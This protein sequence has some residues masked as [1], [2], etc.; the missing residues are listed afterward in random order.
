M[1]TINDL[2][3]RQLLHGQ[4]AMTL[5]SLA[6][7]TP[8]NIQ[9]LLE[10]KTLATKGEWEV[11]WG[12]CVKESNLM[13]VA[14]N[15]TNNTYMVTIRGTIASAWS[16]FEDVDSYTIGPLPW[17]NN[18]EKFIS[19]GMRDGWDHLNSMIDSSSGLNLFQFVQKI[20]DHSYIYVTGH[21]QGGG[22]STVM[23]FYLHDSFHPKQYIIPYTMAGETAGN[24][25]FAHAYNIRFDKQ[26]ET[27]GLRFFNNIDVV[28][29]GFSDMT[30]IKSLYGT[31]PPFVSCPD[32]FDLVIDTLNKTLP[33]YEQ[34]KTG[35][36]LPGPHVPIGGTVHWY[37]RRSLFISELEIQHNH[38][39]YLW[40]L[41]APLTAGAPTVWPPKSIKAPRIFSCF[42]N[43]LF[44]K[45]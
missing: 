22:L 40:L 2:T 5:S 24:P 6:Y 30:S 43:Y 11:V 27:S 32:S 23:A 14:K 26:D 18:D 3:P 10:N 41:G 33:T 8:Y 39:T 29:K 34:P 31:E 36:S 28:P 38:L 19:S 42:L 16:I 45:K 44:G 15:K 25:A 35:V 13:F 21:S 20:P 1:K 9:N 12:P 4:I 37:N 17:D 7:D